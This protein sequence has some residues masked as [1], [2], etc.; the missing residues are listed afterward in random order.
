[1]S[2]DKFFCRAL[3]PQEITS[4]ENMLAS[5]GRIAEAVGTPLHL[6]GRQPD[7]DTLQRVLKHLHWD[8]HNEVPFTAVGLAFGR[9]LAAAAPLSWVKIND[10]W[11]EE[12]SLKL[13]G[14]EYFIHPASMIVKRA[15]Q[16]EEIDLHYLFDEL[17]RRVRE[18]GPKQMPTRN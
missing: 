16:G 9:V 13:E 11:G 2:D 6:D 7:L 8:E 1:M 14:Y 17:I 12:I 18:D 5:L 4:M 3:N 10:E 15:E